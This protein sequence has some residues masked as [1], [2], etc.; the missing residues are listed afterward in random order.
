M[1]SKRSRGAKKAWTA[2]RDR[3]V[4]K[5]REKKKERKALLSWRT[6]VQNRTSAPSVPQRRKLH[7]RRWFNFECSHQ[8]IHT[9]K[10]L[11]DDDGPNCDARTSR[12]SSSVCLMV[13]TTTPACVTLNPDNTS[14][15]RTIYENADFGAGDGSLNLRLYQFSGNT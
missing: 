10:I 14:F 6:A 2:S 9:P 5:A 13:R 3:K 11:V 12:I 8:G 15:P 1:A 4:A 7:G